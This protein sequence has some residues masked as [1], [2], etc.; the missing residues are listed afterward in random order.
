LDTSKWY[1]LSNPRYTPAVGQATDNFFYVGAYQQPAITTPNDPRPWR[2]NR[3]PLL[4]TAE[5]SPAW[6]LD[7]VIVT[8]GSAR[9]GCSYTNAT[10]AG[11]TPSG[12][13]T[14]ASAGAGGGGGSPALPIVNSARAV[15]GETV[16]RL[17]GGYPAGGAQ[18]QPVNSSDSTRG[19][20]LRLARTT[21]DALIILNTQI[22][23][24]PGKAGTNAGTADVI[25]AGWVKGG[26][27]GT[28]STRVGLVRD[29]SL[30][31]W[32]VPFTDTAPLGPPTAV[33]EIQPVRVTSD[34]P[35][36]NAIVADV[37]VAAGVPAAGGFG[38]QSLV[39]GLTNGQSIIGHNATTTQSLLA[40][41]PLISLN[42][43]GTC[44]VD[45]TTGTYTP[46]AYDNRTNTLNYM[47]ATV[48]SG[49]YKYTLNATTSAVPTLPVIRTTL[50]NGGWILSPQLNAIFRTDS[51]GNVYFASS[52]RLYEA[53]HEPID[54]ALPLF[55]TVSMSYDPSWGEV[56]D[57]RITP[58][59]EFYVLYVV[60]STR[61]SR[62]RLF[63]LTS[64]GVLSLTNTYTLIT[65]NPPWKSIEIDPISGVGYAA[66]LAGN[67]SPYLFVFPNGFGPTSG[68]TMG[69][70]AGNYSILPQI[71]PCAI[72]V[73]ARDNNLL[74]Y[75]YLPL[76]APLSRDI[77]L[78]MTPYGLTIAD[79]T[80]MVT[81]AYTSPGTISRNG[82]RSWS[83]PGRNL[84]SV[85]LGPR[86]TLF[87]GDTAGNIL[88]KKM[89][90]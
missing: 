12:S 36:N 10:L 9:Y 18:K 40:V 48:T 61:A 76:A 19:Y 33:S 44:L 11:S 28:A 55:R 7:G 78:T 84:N 37:G 65:A 29:T 88:L 69:S 8:T 6:Q 83:H 21:T 13:R 73:A 79:S 74:G 17:I 66:T 42:D 47:G 77:I 56:Q 2:G 31:A 53:S 85:C 49:V 63:T 64:A 54:G 80:G 82:V 24:N 23:T 30:T 46:L 43:T 27:D 60:P 52:T 22:A 3:F 4:T 57:F 45:L 14:L 90:F 51:N 16:E 86:G 75:A 70:G 68:N 62:I 38:G 20:N 58:K 87:V 34:S 25:T 67:A 26:T 59:N 41:F 89:K 81:F 35:F 5:T 72:A 71:S 1:Y 50:S 15:A 32:N 39:S